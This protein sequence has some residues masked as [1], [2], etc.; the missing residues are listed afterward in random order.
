MGFF[1]S[2]GNVVSSVAGAF[3]GTN[4]I[5]GATS[6]ATGGSIG[7]STPIGSL[8]GGL[9]APGG[10]ST[11]PA[12]PTEGQLALQ[13]QQIA[14]GDV[15]LQAGTDVQGDLELLRQQLGMDPSE[16][17]NL[18][19]TQAISQLGR[20]GGLTENFDRLQEASRG[21]ARRGGAL[22]GEAGDLRSQ[23]ERLEEQFQATLLED[24]PLAEL[25][26]SLGRDLQGLRGQ[27]Q[28]VRGRDTGLRTQDQELRDIARQGI[29]SGFAATPEQARL[30]EQIASGQIASGT[31]DIE[32]AFGRSLGLV[33][34]ELAPS[35]GLRST[36][37]P[38]I[39]RGGV[40][41]GENLRLQQQLISGARTQQAQNLLNFPLQAGALQQQSIAGQ[42]TGIRGQQQL[43]QGELQALLGQQGQVLGEQAG[44]R[45]SRQLVQGE[46]NAI[47]GQQAAGRGSQAEIRALINSLQGQ[48]AQNVNQTQAILGQQQLGLNFADFQDRLNLRSLESRLNVAQ[49]G[50]GLAGLPTSSVGF[51]TPNVT[52][53]TAPG[54]FAGFISGA[55]SALGASLL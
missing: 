44:V 10:T 54:P 12:A 35:R 34:E 26:R 31:S 53:T 11:Q 49:T 2:V 17:E 41:A 42:Q 8:A 47:L 21:A 50:L 16:F 28:D 29:E 52:E 38:I 7:G 39:D 55:G 23:G 32:A 5:T 40:L 13:A 6:A 30:I 51:T 46:A 48:Q 19:S 4:L 27:F 1:S 14:Q 22:E 43:T 45:G 24:D 3:I 20:Q 15:S 9:T 33:R 36:D 18:I 37:S 25:E